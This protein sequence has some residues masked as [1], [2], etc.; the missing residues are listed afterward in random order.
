MHKFL[1]AAIALIS[2]SSLCIAEKA[3]NVHVK[4]VTNY[5]DIVL[6]LYPSKAPLTVKNF[7][8]YVDESFYNGTIFHRVIKDFMIQGGGFTPN[9]KMKSA[10]ENIQNESGNGLKN[11]RGYISMARTTDPHSANSQF[12]INVKDNDYLN[13]TSAAPGGW[14][15]TVFG[16]VIEGLNVVD[17]ISKSPTGPAGIFEQDAPQGT[18]IIKRAER[19]TIKT[20]PQPKKDKS[21]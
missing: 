17:E 3:E 11:S 21:K 8:R 4:F 12:F 9:Y 16:K 6:E 13:F 1:L 19:M 14:G 15:Y 10:H 20:K 7:L 2:A 18:I 5:G